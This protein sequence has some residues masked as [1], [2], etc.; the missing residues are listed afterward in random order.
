[1][2]ETEVTRAAWRTLSTFPPPFPIPPLLALLFA[3]YLALLLFDTRLVS[4]PA[5]T[6][7][8]QVVASAGF[9]R[10]VSQ[11][12]TLKT[13]WARDAADTPDENMYQRRRL[14]YSSLKHRFNASTIT[15]QSHGVFPF[16]T[17]SADT[18][19]VAYTAS[20]VTLSNSRSSPS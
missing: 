7:F 3:V 6:R 14:L 17:A 10:D 5:P 13:L 1:M 4:L 11:N 19:L 16:N 18:L 15:P 12:R 8:G 2:D 20:T 9:G